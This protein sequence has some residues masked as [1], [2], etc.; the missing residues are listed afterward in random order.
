MPEA[1][2]V[3]G[4]SRR[5]SIARRS[6]WRPCSSRRSVVSRGGAHDGRVAL[7]SIAL[8][9]IAAWSPALGWNTTTGMPRRRRRPDLL[10]R[11]G[12]GSGGGRAGSRLSERALRDVDI[13]D[14]TSTRS[15][16]SLRSDVGVRRGVHAAVDVLRPSISTGWKY[17][18]IAA[19]AATAVGE[20]GLR[21]APCG[22]APPG[23]RRPCA[24]CR[25]RAGPYGQ[26]S[27]VMRARSAPAQLSV[28]TRPAGNVTPS[29][30]SGRIFSGSGHRPGEQAGV[31]AVRPVAGTDR[32]GP[33]AGRA[34]AADQ[35]G[36]LVGHLLDREHRGEVGD[37]EPE[38]QV[39]ADAGAGRRP[40]DDRR[41]A[42]VPAGRLEQRRR[43]R[44]HG[45]P[46]R[47]G[48]RRRGRVRS[49][50]RRDIIA[51]GG[52]ANRPAPGHGAPTGQ[53][54]GAGGPG[55]PGPRRGTA[56]GRRRWSRA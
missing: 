46:G 44:P 15:R 26:S 18:G 12:A 43:A 42:R 41:V 30:A 27:P 4:R 23:G 33:V 8:P 21:R 9:P 2:A 32:G 35:L 19:D 3:R 29:T 37:A 39:G 17:P 10:A 53:P 36:A 52:V 49:V 14:D 55:R 16:S 5:R 31:R 22:R 1:R 56:A 13:G 11:A 54:G 50:S 51:D 48:R 28:G 38:P 24:P 47:S 20:V 40:D 7:V 6:A 34:E 45:T 25:S